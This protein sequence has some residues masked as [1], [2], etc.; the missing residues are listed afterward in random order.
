[1]IGLGRSFRTVGLFAAGG[2]WCLHSYQSG[3]VGEA[4]EALAWCGGIYF[5]VGAALFILELVFSS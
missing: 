1:M 2:S 3:G 4:A 5:V